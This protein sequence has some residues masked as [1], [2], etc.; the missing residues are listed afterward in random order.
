MKIIYG[1]AFVNLKINYQNRRASVGKASSY[2]Q[3]YILEYS[4]KVDK[5]SCSPPFLRVGWRTNSQIL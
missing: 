4:C 3:D 5:S 2:L 1:A